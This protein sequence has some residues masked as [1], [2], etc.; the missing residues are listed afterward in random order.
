MTRAPA[1]LLALAPALL[2]SSGCEV[3]SEY[4]PTVA[5]ERLDVDSV[6]W[7]GAT[8]D[9][10]FKVN[11]P[12]PI[13]VKLARF[14][15]SL[16]FAD[17]QWL[18]GDDPD[19]LILDAEGG[20]ELALPVTIEFETLYEVVQATRGIDTIPFGLEGSFGFNTP[21][22]VVDLPYDAEGGFPAL[23]TPTFG[24]QKVRVD[25][26]DWSSATIAVDLGVDNDHES[27]LD[28]TN[29][30]YALELDGTSVGT[31]FLADLG[32]VDGAQTGTLSVPFTI[33]FLDAG[34]AI[35]EAITSGEVDVG[36]KAATD[37]QTPFGAVPLSVDESGRVSV[38]L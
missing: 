34:T 38:D 19:G 1:S 6:D 14:D 25:E 8:A 20:S 22:G 7:E 4:L 21:A 30:D 37:V 17:V 26:L 27:T 10:V 31:G 5:F 29:F 18:E 23:R 3:I 13:E 2:L 24:F 28:F 11:N 16:A 36:L 32:A 15:Y 12:N 35:Y 9:F 33:D